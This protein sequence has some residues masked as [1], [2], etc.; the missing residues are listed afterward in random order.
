MARAVTQLRSAQAAS[1]L[2]SAPGSG[3]TTMALYAADALLRDKTVDLCIFLVPL[4]VML[5]WQETVAGLQAAGALAEAHV[6][7]YTSSSK[8]LQWPPQLQSG[9]GSSS[10]EPR[11]ALMFFSYDF[12][13]KQFEQGGRGG[14]L[15]RAVARTSTLLVTDELTTSYVF[16]NGSS[17]RAVRAFMQAA[18]RKLV[19]SAQLFLNHGVVEETVRYLDVLG[20]AHDE[21]PRKHDPSMVETTKHPAGLVLGR[22]SGAA[23]CGRVGLPAAR[24]DAAGGR[25]VEGCCRAGRALPGRR[26]GRQ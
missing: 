2:S 12:A 6:A 23:A 19:L 3:K 17:G 21:V 5:Q 25:A 22:H 7:F 16:A 4:V 15:C 26:K 9:A 24:G 18:R 13:V 11:R 8:T 20:V 10:D 1:V 14:L